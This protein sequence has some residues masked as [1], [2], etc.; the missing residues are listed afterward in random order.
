MTAESILKVVSIDKPLGE[1]G[2][3]EIIFKDGCDGAGQQ[4]VWKSTSMNESKN[5][6]FQYGITPLKLT[7]NKN[8]LTEVLWENHTPNSC[9]TLR[10]LF[11]IREKE[12][13]SNL[14]NLV[15]PI[16][17]KVCSELALDGVCV[18]IGN[19]Y[20]NIKIT[21]HDSMKDLKFKKSISGLGGANCLLY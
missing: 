11:L 14:L 8:G 2:T 16:T 18:P 12:T 21:I 7:C 1:D 6:M 9:K 15:I 5:N 19:K 17:D 10:P 13:D 4:V 3:L 20:V